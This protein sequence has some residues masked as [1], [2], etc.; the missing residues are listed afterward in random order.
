VQHFEAPIPA[1]LRST[2][3]LELYYLKCTQSE[4]VDF[5]GM[6]VSAKNCWKYREQVVIVEI[7]ARSVAVL[8]LQ[9]N[10]ALWTMQE[11]QIVVATSIH[12]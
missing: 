12:G 1:S 3:G 6:F 5:P 7:H 9:N 11:L 4:W 8:T 2:T 10:I